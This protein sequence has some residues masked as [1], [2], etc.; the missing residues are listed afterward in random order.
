MQFFTKNRILHYFSIK[1]IPYK[2]LFKVRFCNITLHLSCNPTKVIFFIIRLENRV[3]YGIIFCCNPLT[4]NVIFGSLLTE[5]NFSCNPLLEIAL[6]QW[7]FNQKLHFFLYSLTKIVFF[8]LD[9]YFFFSN[10]EI[11]L[12]SARFVLF[13]VVFQP[14]LLPFHPPLPIKNAIKF[15]CIFVLIPGLIES[16]AKRKEFNVSMEG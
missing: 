4:K 1:I 10:W 11:C 15:W 13:F 14:L 16:S 2:F 12:F 3:R 9:T 7:F 8:S 5:V 6:F